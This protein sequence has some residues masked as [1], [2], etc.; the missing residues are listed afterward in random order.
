MPSNLP[1]SPNSFFARPSD[2][3]RNDLLVRNLTPYRT[4][5]YKSEPY[6]PNVIVQRDLSPVN[7]EDISNELRTEAELGTILNLYA[8]TDFVDAGELINTVSLFDGVGVR[9]QYN[10]VGT[11]INTEILH[12]LETKNR[13][14]PDGGYNA[15]Y[16]VTDNI[17]NKD[18]NVSYPQF[19]SG[20]YNVYDVLNGTT[21]STDSYL[22]QLSLTFLRETFQQ[23]VNAEIQRQTIGRVN[24][25]AFSNPFDAALLAS[26]EQ[27]VIYKNYT[28]TVPDGVF[29]QAAFLLQ[30][31][32]GTY[33]PA[34]PIEG[35]YFTD[36]Q[37]QKSK[38]GQFFEGTRLGKLATK[39]QN[40]ENPSVKFLA[41][42]G[43]GQKSVLFNSISY[44]RYKPAYDL[45]RTQVGEFID[46]VFNRDN[47]IGTYY[48]G[49]ETNEISQITSPPDKVPIDAWGNTT[50]T[51]V[52][53]PDKLGKLYEGDQI[54]NFQFGLAGAAYTDQPRND[55]GFTWVNNELKNEAGKFQG[56]GGEL[57]GTSPSYRLVGSSLEA[58]ESTNA[59]FRPGS[60]LDQTQRLVNSTPKKGKDRLSHVGNAINQLSKVFDDG[61]KEITKGSKVKK[62]V[63]RSGVEVGTEYGRVFTKDIPYFTYSNLQS[64]VA[65][66]SGGETNGNLRRFSY[67]VLDSTYNLN[68]AP[69][70]GVGSTNIVGEGPNR[71]VKKYMFSIE[72]LAWKNSP[73]YE[74][75]PACEKG[76]NG[77]RIMWFP[78]YELTFDDGST[79]QFHETNF[80]GRPEPIFTYQNTKRSGN[81]SFKIIVDH[82]S[83]L[84]LI[85][86]KELQ[87]QDSFTTNQ[88]VNSFFAGCKKY[89]IY[90]L[91]RKFNTVKFSTLNELYQ[92]ILASNKSSQDDIA[93]VAS[94]I[95][96]SNNNPTSND[97]TNKID[98]YQNTRFYFNPAP[99]TSVL[100][101]ESYQYVEENTRNYLTEISQLTLAANVDADFLK[102]Q[103]I[104]K[105]V[106]EKTD[107]GST[108]KIVLTPA[109][110]TIS[111][112][113]METSIKQ[114]FGEFFYENGDSLQK[115][116]DNQKLTLE[117]SSTVESNINVQNSEG[118]I[119]V[120][121]PDNYDP[122]PTGVTSSFACA[123][124]VISNIT[125]T[126]P[127]PEPQGSNQ[128]AN[129]TPNQASLIGNPVN[130]PTT[131][132][133]DKY[134]KSLSKRII[135]ELMTEYDYFE[136]IIQDT[137]F[138]FDSIKE[139]IKF[140][141]PA[142]HSITPEGF[143]SRLTFLNQCVRPGRTVPSIGENGEKVYNDAYNTNFGTPPILILRIGDFY[144]CKIVPNSLTFKYETL[145]FNP[146]GIGVQPMI[147]NVSL[148]FSMI[149]GH[150]LKEPISKLQNALSFNFYANTEMYDERA[151][152]TEDTT[153]IDNELLNS[154]LNNE[155]LST[156]SDVN[157]IPKNEGAEVIGTILENNPDPS[158]IQTGKISYK[159]IFD[160]YIDGQSGY[161]ESFTGFIQ[162]TITDFNYG[163]YKQVKT[164]RLFST[165]YSNNL[166]SGKTEFEI[167]GRS[168]NWKELLTN[169]GAKLKEFIDGETELII[170]N[171]KN[172]NVKSVDLD[173]IKNNYK[174]LI[175]E[176]VNNGFASLGSQINEF[177]TNQVN[178]LQTL[179][180][181]DVV[182]TLTDGKI[183]ADKS[184][185]IYVLT[186]V[187]LTGA[188]ESGGDSMVKLVSDYTTTTA[189]FTG[190][191][192]TLT[193]KFIS[194]GVS[195]APD[196]FFETFSSMNSSGATNVCYTLFSND[197][198]DTNK[199]QNFINNLKK[200]ISTG[201]T[202]IINTVITDRV[203]EY[204]TIF[205]LEKE[206]TTKAFDLIING[207]N[208]LSYKNY[209]P[210][211][212]NGKAVKG[213]ERN[214][215]FVTSGGTITQE[216]FIRNLYSSVNI[217]NDNTSFND[218]KTF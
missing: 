84:N 104:R 125:V 183:L 204:S 135:R 134:K 130:N 98:G 109:K 77:G 86:D 44:N 202:E 133:P 168:D 127:T 190:Y 92:E 201:Q 180:K 24:L 218:K 43:S 147:V 115:Y 161:F 23:R 75:L 42:T 193:T 70:R 113:D 166:N 217:N 41:N 124:T 126:P 59:A 208:Y 136:T 85:V 214:A 145:D 48:V 101:N 108:V 96:P 64:T 184:V 138:F 53:G 137:P 97:D 107:A 20:E 87:K 167:F 176:K 55:G 51:P 120:I 203:E 71:K 76:A 207:P 52:Y 78:P 205:N 57:F 95:P 19:V 111:T 164:N 169:V 31:I 21:T 112:S 182:S 99:D 30:K 139:K 49:G 102:L 194:F 4:L 114:F 150:G 151:D 121:C 14:I 178:F 17:L 50:Q 62:Y 5:N 210:Q 74:D 174:N 65:N 149:G 9:G 2:K 61:Y 1:K 27:P 142:F 128:T 153:A 195:E 54:S 106:A 212:S 10:V 110:T 163:V 185:K 8:T 154:I 118:L 188:T 36:P 192:N 22:Q 105:N 156:I 93:A 200:N 199:K 89:D 33:I 159:T 131:N 165:G 40:N 83:V 56:E 68:I 181:L 143:N 81:I 144:N 209:N 146:E 171:L 175:D 79:P 119:N 100:N 177:A 47:N 94:E 148:G 173:I 117:F 80:I 155:P 37:N 197:I 13:F 211:D 116:L 25:Q 15:L 39:L 3:F 67:S 69:I 38:L 66:T 206:E 215:N 72:N 73:E 58:S 191:M 160:S 34:S 170:F 63:N 103:D 140:F 28:I 60:I 186:G 162:K 26:G 129:S 123:S 198:L 88:V 141:N 216:D 157:N 7:Q 213:L 11:E 122:S 187:T 32:S 91:A 45:N 82:P 189:N 12:L 29:D 132:I 18:I 16:F 179:R 152:I 172:K 90:E 6:R 196:V 158:G 35:N 46:N